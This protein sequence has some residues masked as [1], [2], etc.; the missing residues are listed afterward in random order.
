MTKKRITID[1]VAEAS[2][3]SRTTVSY[4]LNGKCASFQISEATIRKVAETAL[5]LNYHREKA[6][7]ALDGLESAK[8]SVLVLSPWLYAQH[9][10]FMAQL[11]PAF[12]AMEEQYRFE[13]VYMQYHSGQ[14]GKVLRPM[15]FSRYDAVVITGTSDEDNAYLAR[16]REK[17]SRVILLNRRV[18]GI[19]SVSGNDREASLGLGRQ[20]CAQ[21]QYEPLL[22]I[23]DRSSW[24]SRFR[25][26]GFL[27]AAAEADRRIEV[28]DLDSQALTE[29]LLQKAEAFLGERGLVFFTQYQPAAM[30][31]IR[32]P[33][34]TTRRGIACYD[35]DKSIRRFLPRQ[36]TTLDPCITE[37]AREAAR[38]ARQLKE[39]AQPEPVV[40]P[41]K[42]IQGETAVLASPAE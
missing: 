29:E 21:M 31:L 37:M 38:M 25:K 7:A 10:D 36:L 18:E 20:L 27:Q 28:W 32:R 3:I 6:Q 22:L 15:I 1:D 17:L 24:C 23:S 9:S 4:I 8:V 12:K 40:I 30:L 42:L 33:E 41:A 26:E 35:E 5:Q 16:N 19:L 13:F 14:L 39:G 11:H 34:D 2:G